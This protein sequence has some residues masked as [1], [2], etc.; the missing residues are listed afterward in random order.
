MLGEVLCLSVLPICICAFCFVQ[1]LI[2]CIKCQMEGQE[3]GESKQ[4]RKMF[5]QAAGSLTLLMLL[6]N[7]WVLFVT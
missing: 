3:L 6:P 4:Y 5:L 1:G 2:G 7:P